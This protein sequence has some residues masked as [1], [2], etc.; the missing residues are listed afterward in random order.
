MFREIKRLRYIEYFKKQFYVDSYILNNSYF[1]SYQYF[2]QKTE[3]TLIAKD[4]SRIIIFIRN[5]I[6]L[7][8]TELNQDEIIDL[9]NS[10]FNKNNLPYY[11]R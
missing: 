4:D 6:P 10:E 9:L 2:H 8:E 7:F 1:K 11:I 3:D 5:I